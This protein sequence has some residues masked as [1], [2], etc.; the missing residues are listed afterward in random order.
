MST[1]FAAM[2]TASNALD[3][4]EQAIGVVQN[5]VSNANTPGYVTQSLNLTARAFDAANDLW[6]GVQAS[7]VESA[8]NIYAEQAVWNA[9][10]QAGLV[11]QQASSLASLETNFDVSGTSGI[12]AALSGLYSAFSAWSANPTDATSEQQVLA[13]A[14]A[15]S[16]SFNQTSASI[17][18]LSSQT[19][20]QLAGTVSQINQYAA[21][22]ATINGEIRQ[23]GA[24]DAGLQTQ[25]YN[26]LEQLSNL[27]PISV[28]TESDGT[29]TVLL[30]GQAPLVLGQTANTLAVSYAADPSPT[31]PGGAPAAQLLT[32]DGQDVT[33]LATAGQLGALLQFRNATL[34]SVIGSG[35]QQGSLNQLAQ[36]IADRVNTLLTSGQTASGA[37]GVALFS[38]NASALTAAA[39]SLT[40][41]PSI[42][43][44]ELAASDPGPPVASNGIASQLAQLASPESA[45]DELNGLSYTDFYSGVAAGIGQQAS[46]ATT[47]QQTQSQ[48]LTQA[49][50]ARAQ[51]SGVSLNEQATQLLEFQQGYQAAAQVITVINNITQSL[52][53]TMQNL[54]G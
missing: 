31:Y 17:Q 40:V 1:L 9:N 45:A 3:V 5:N 29:A 20:Q 16:Q 26:T 43:A 28:R 21:Q 7:G 15:L 36:G 24:G 13:A 48:L 37:A 32:N 38:Y 23:G 11:T 50:S 14:Q 51:S 52:L 49:Q 53:T 35:E 39:S 46:S 54:Q 25:L 41:N 42:S 10:Q 47:A 34:P 19:D 8:R 6:G 33:A 44:S 27:A 30:G 2:G 18:Q 4:L 12:P 22:I